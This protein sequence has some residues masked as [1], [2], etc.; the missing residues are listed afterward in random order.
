MD[1]FKNRFEGWHVISKDQQ[2]RIANRLYAWYIQPIEK[3]KEKK[4][5]LKY[6]YNDASFRQLY[7]LGD[8]KPL[9]NDVEIPKN[10]K[11]TNFNIDLISYMKESAEQLVKGNYD[12]KEFNNPSIIKNR[13]KGFKVIKSILERMEKMQSKISKMPYLADT[14]QSEREGFQ[15]MVDELEKKL[16]LST[17]DLSIIASRFKD[18]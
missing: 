13:Y 6:I 16:S 3:E 12:K 1:E 18:S 4:K 17:R 7:E 5:A 15:F 2:K 9:T 14:L 8:K 11:G 10:L